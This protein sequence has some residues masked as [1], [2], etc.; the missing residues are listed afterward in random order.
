MSEQQRSLFTFTVSRKDEN[1]ELVEVK[2]EEYSGN[3]QLGYAPRYE[4]WP[5]CDCLRCHK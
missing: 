4:S 1:G 3:D 5:L 2:R